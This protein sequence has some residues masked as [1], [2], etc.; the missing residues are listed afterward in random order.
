MSCILRISGENFDVDLCVEG[1]DVEFS[2]IYRKGDPRY[3]ASKPNGPKLEHS[4]LSVEVSSADFSDMNQQL[5]DAID[6]LNKSSGLIRELV[7]FKGVEYALLDF[8]VETKPP[9]W[10]SYTFP[11]ELAYLAGQLGLGLCVSTYPVDEDEET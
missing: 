2:N 6:F 8:G 7:E 1:K 9:F 5:E 4:G 3:P 10:A 11:P